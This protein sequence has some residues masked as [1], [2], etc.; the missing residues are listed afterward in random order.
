MFCIKCFHRADAQLILPV[1]GFQS[2]L[3]D[4]WADVKLGKTAKTDKKATHLKLYLNYWLVPIQ[5]LKSLQFSHSVTGT[6]NPLWETWG[7]SGGKF[8]HH[9]WPPNI[10]VKLWRRFKQHIL[11]VTT[12]SVIR[13]AGKV[14]NIH[15]HESTARWQ[16]TS[17]SVHVLTRNQSSQG[18]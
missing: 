3:M 7:K 2:P 13:S 12:I 15:T 8:Q 1:V 10:S 14:K 18:C 4:T 5:E 16:I 6:V 9:H 11:N 17:V